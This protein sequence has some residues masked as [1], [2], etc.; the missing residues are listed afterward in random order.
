LKLSQVQSNYFIDSDTSEI[1]YF[2]PL[3]EQVVTYNFNWYFKWKVNSLNRNGDP[4][5]EFSG[6]TKDVLENKLN[7]IHPFAVQA[8]GQISSFAQPFSDSQEHTRNESY[9]FKVPRQTLSSL[10]TQYSTLEG[11]VERLDSIDGW[12]TQSTTSNFSG[13]KHYVGYAN[14][15][16]L[17]EMNGK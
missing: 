17:R 2:W 4:Y 6:S 16:E 7:Q 3:A 14:L 9:S 1:V 12:V 15:F 10:G 11:K 13:D 8:D 5:R